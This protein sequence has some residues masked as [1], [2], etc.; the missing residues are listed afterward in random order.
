M[1]IKNEISSWQL[2]KRLFK[3]YILE[4]KWKLVLASLSMILIALTTASYAKFMEPLIDQVLV[5]RDT[6][7]IIFIPLI[8]LTISVVKAIATYTQSF[9]LG[10]FGQRIIAEI[11]NNLFAKLVNSDLKFFEINASGALISKFLNDANLLREALT[12]SLTGISKD[13][14]T[15]I[16]LIILLFST[17]WQLALI[18]TLGFPISFFPVRKIGKRMRKAS[19]QNQEKTSSFSS[20]L[21][22]AFMNS[23]QIKSYTNEDKEIKK[24]R[25]SNELRLKAMFKVVKTRAAATPLIEILAGIFT[26]LV[27]LYAV[28][29]EDTSNRLTA[30]QFVTFITALGLSYQPLRSIANLN[31][32]LQEGLAAADRIFKI[33]D[34]KNNINDDTNAELLNITQGKILFKNVSFSYGENNILHDVNFE[35]KVGKSV[36]IVGKSGAGKSTLLN[37][38]SRFID[39]TS[40]KILIDDQEIRLVTQSSLRKNIS[41]VT[42]NANLFNI[43]IFENILYGRNDATEEEVFEAANKA[44]CSEFI[45]QLPNKF[46]T[47]VGE[48]GIKL[49]GGQK[50]RISIARAFLKNAPIILLDEAT[51]ALDTESE[52]KIQQALD[53]LI[54]GKTTIIVAHRLSTIVGAD[55]IITIHDG[56]I[57]ERG[58]H[59]S[60]IDKGGMYS[61]LYN[62]DIIK[63]I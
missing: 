17:D 52:K 5:N 34:T 59:T 49:S 53:K 58:T 29:F 11:Q 51:S 10:V 40:G 14:L 2:I 46:N 20:L 18:A 24:V 56:K 28:G 9:I 16:F 4:H 3:G 44:F 22:E 1:D 6:T 55:Q 37:L 7:S 26:A 39:P 54:I 19:I 15:L 32:A 45:H 13:F 63:N 12:K 27:I 36:A 48:S 21:N 35:A 62:E 61:K 30:G 42:Q 23:I 25:E 8:F 50:Q 43:S 57:V 33:L 41:F 38:I 60:L 31:T 47:I